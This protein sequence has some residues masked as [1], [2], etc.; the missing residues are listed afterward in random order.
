MI[1]SDIVAVFNDADMM[2]REA[3]VRFNNDDIR[4]AAEKAWCAVRTATDA[5][6]MAHGQERPTRS[7][8]TTRMLQQ[9][10][11]KDNSLG[12]MVDFYFRAQGELHGQCFYFGLYELKSLGEQMAA[13]GRYIVDAKSKAA[14]VVPS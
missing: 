6:I 4:D 8:A 1:N 11:A 14:A 5:L 9:L 10:H 13:V 2:Y 3:Q 12:H 7:P